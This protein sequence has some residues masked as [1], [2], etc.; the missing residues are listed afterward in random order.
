MALA[1]IHRVLRPG[2]RL[3]FLDLA[4][5]THSML[6]QILHG[7]QLHAAAAERL[8]RRMREAG[9]TDAKRVNDRGTLFGR[10]AYYQA[11]KTP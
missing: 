11:S 3:E 8:L 10:I 5:G 7:R 1:E 9:L 2:G 6:A 4:G